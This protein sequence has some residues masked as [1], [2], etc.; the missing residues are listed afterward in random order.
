MAIEQVQATAKRAAE[1]AAQLYKDYGL[2]IIY[3]I[4]VFNVTSWIWIV[5]ELTTRKVSEYFSDV[6]KS[7]LSNKVTRVGESN[8]GYFKD[9][10]WGH[11][12]DNVFGTELPLGALVVLDV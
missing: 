8:V 11:C 5:K 4:K 9:L 7:Y 6:I 3:M 1:G 12:Y 10:Y 2:I